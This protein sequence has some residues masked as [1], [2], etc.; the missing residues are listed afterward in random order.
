[1]RQV[2]GPLP[3]ALPLPFPSPAWEVQYPVLTH[4]TPPSARPP[5]AL[6]ASG[7]VTHGAAVGR[8]WGG[9]WEFRGK[10]AARR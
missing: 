1:M 4:R 5:E 3:S 9:T 8:S 7:E 10:G 6:P 2:G